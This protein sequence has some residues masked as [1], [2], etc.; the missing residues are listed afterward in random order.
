M[1]DPVT[2]PCL[3]V[4]NGQAP[5]YIHLERGASI[6]LTVHACP[7]GYVE[8]M[9]AGEPLQ[10]AVHGTI[11]RV[12]SAGATIPLSFPISGT[13]ELTWAAASSVESW[14]ATSRIES[15]GK[16]LM[17]QTIARNKQV[18]PIIFSVGVEVRS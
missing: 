10:E 11:D 13:Y 6:D 17:R 8:W 9:L 15:Q 1:T 7:L 5:L 2:Q 3:D 18:S 14:A 12:T 4:G 16:E